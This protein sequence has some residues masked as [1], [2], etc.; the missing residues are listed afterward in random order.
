MSDTV[1]HA[2][3]RHKPDETVENYVT[4]YFENDTNDVM[5][6]ASDCGLGETFTG[7][8]LS[9]ALT[10]I[11]QVIDTKLQSADKRL[12]QLLVR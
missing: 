12:Q 8:S 5:I 6:V 2:L 7:T 11:K 9:E 4:L 1:I 3:Y 10:F